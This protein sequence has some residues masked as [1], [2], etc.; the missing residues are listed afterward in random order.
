MPIP[1][2]AIAT[3][4]I[5]GAGISGILKGISGFFK[6]K[7]I[8]ADTEAKINTEEQRK[9]IAEE[10][11][12]LS[13]IESLTAVSKAEKEHV[14]LTSQMRMQMTKTGLS[15][16]GQETWMGQT[17]AGMEAE[18][19][20]L[21]TSGKRR[22]NVMVGRLIGYKAIFALMKLLANGHNGEMLLALELK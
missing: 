1:L 10:N 2:A 18:K 7:A 6:D 17:L 12:E 14:Y 9:E 13:D 4:V 19:E 20:T 16:M 15:P 11:V 21:V 8:V 3:G 5:I 22:L